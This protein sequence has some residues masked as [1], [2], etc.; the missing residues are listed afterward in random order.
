MAVDEKPKHVPKDP[1]F[2]PDL[3]ILPPPQRETPHRYLDKSKGGRIVTSPE[4]TQYTVTCKKCGREEFADFGVHGPEFI[5]EMLKQAGW[6]ITGQ[7]K[8]ARALCDRCLQ[9]KPAG[10]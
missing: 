10:Q 4:T 8:N 2:T 5:P 7:G 3:S 9:G 6:V 1:P